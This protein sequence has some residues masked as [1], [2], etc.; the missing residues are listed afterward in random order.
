M[1]VLP[2]EFSNFPELSVFSFYQHAPHCVHPLSLPSAG[3]PAAEPP[4]NSK[5]GRCSSFCFP[6]AS[7]PHQHRRSSCYTTRPHSHNF[8]PGLESLKA[9]VLLVV[10]GH[11]FLPTSGKQGVSSSPLGLCIQ[12]A[13]RSPSS[14]DRCTW[15]ATQPDYGGHAVPKI[16]KGTPCFTVHASHNPSRERAQR[17]TLPAYSHRTAVH[18]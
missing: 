9:R 17:R 5:Y 18:S 6:R 2:A 7:I 16:Q 4:R 13:A 10:R 8:P 14:P 3:S 12:K 1:M 11:L 15:Y